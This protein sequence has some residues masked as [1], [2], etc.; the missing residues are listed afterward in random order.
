MGSSRLAVRSRPRRARTMTVFLLS[1]DDIP[2]TSDSVRQPLS[3]RHPSMDVGGHVTPLFALVATYMLWLNSALSPFLLGAIA[4]VH[5]VGRWPAS[6]PARQQQ[7]HRCGHGSIG[8]FVDG[9]RGDSIG[10][11]PSGHWQRLWWWMCVATA[12][13]NVVML[14]LMSCDVV[15]CPFVW[16][17]CV[18]LL[19]SF[20]L[21]MSLFVGL[22]V[23]SLFA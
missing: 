20:S 7:Q 17:V 6:A 18:C 16:C 14:L 12:V 21:F 9:R 13:V 8:C 11:C 23:V 2:A 4:C 15:W 5:T 3:T 10:W 22:F 19:V 1:S